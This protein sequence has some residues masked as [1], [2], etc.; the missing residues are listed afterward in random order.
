[1]ASYYDEKLMNWVGIMDADQFYRECGKS[2]K[3]FRKLIADWDSIAG[4]TLH[5]EVGGVSLC[6]YLGGKK[7]KVFGLAPQC[8]RIGRPDRVTLARADFVRY[9]SKNRAAKREAELLA[10]A[11]A[12]TEVGAA[13]IEVL[14]PG[15]LPADKQVALMKAIFDVF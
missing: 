4:C 3:F 14:D 10:A 2:R 6:A 8:E 12:Q 15:R 11:G 5:W 9:I 7:A 1:M 13:S